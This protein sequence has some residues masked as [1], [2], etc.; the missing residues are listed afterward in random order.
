MEGQYLWRRLPSLCSNDSLHHSTNLS[1]LF[2]Y[3]SS[4]WLSID[5]DNIPNILVEE[6][7]KFSNVF[8]DRSIR[9][10]NIQCG[11]SFNDGIAFWIVQKKKKSEIKTEEREK[12]KKRKTPNKK[13]I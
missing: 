5:A 12:N 13:K 1:K 10:D 3:P 9:K 8:E 4:S 6:Q 11:R 2:P 7:N